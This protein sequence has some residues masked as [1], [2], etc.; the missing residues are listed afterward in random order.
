MC[1]TFNNA[2]A[3]LNERERVVDSAAPDATATPTAITTAT[4]CVFLSSS[5]AYPSPAGRAWA[6]RLQ[7]LRVRCPLTHQML[8]L[9][10]A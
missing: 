8:H 2:P 1:N 3:Q 9:Q 4:S 5:R 6:I 7:L 10:S